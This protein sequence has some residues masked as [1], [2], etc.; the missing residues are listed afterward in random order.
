MHNYHKQPNVE[1]S[2]AFCTTYNS[3][4]N[5]YTYLRSSSRVQVMRF[6]GLMYVLIYKLKDALH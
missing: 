3:W 6:P 2:Y 1:H 4:E 5:V